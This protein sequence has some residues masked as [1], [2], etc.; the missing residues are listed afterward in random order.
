[1]VAAGVWRVCAKGIALV[2]FAADGGDM[3][4]SQM[5]YTAMKRQDGEKMVQE[6]GWEGTIRGDFNC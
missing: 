2:V 5:G 4:V 6:D 3:E 1:M